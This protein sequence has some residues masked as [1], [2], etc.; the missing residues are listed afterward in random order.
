MSGVVQVTPQT[1]FEGGLRALFALRQSPRCAT[2]PAPSAFDPPSAVNDS[3]PSLTGKAGSID[4]N[5]H[6][7]KLAPHIRTRHK[8]SR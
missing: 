5:W 4:W 2:F 6:G 8:D 3:P 7:V 1:S